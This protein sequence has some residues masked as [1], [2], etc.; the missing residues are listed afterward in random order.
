MTGIVPALSAAAVGFGPDP[1]VM[2][3]RA[4]ADR[5]RQTRR[6]GFH[7]RLGFERIAPFFNV[8]IAFS[9]DGERALD[10]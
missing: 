1:N 7:T 4:K 9:T 6:F 3:W 2:L 8:I 5:R 10:P